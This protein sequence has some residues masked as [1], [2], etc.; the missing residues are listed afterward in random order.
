[1][2]AHHMLHHFARDIRDLLA[3]RADNGRPAHACVQALFAKIIATLR[4]D[5]RFADISVFTL[6]LVLADA[7]AE[8]ERLIHDAMCNRIHLDD[9]IV[10]DCCLGID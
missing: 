4:R 5:P 10:V 3:A 7:E 8:A 1:M 6:E 2:T 9:A